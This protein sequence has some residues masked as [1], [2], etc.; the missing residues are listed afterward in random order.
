MKVLFFKAIQLLMLTGL[1]GILS[2]CTAFFF[3]PTKARRARL[4]E[5]TPVTADLHR[6]PVAKEK[7]ITAVYK[8]RDLT[9]QYK[10]IEA[11]STFST[12]VTQGTTNILLK[13]LEESGWF[14][15]IE[16]E[17]VSNLL[18]ERKI[19]RSS[20]A[21]YKEGENLPPLLFAGIILEGGVVSY[22]A[23]IITGGGGLQYFSAGG[24]TQYRQDRVTVYLRAV[25][26]KSGKILKTIYT[27]K[28]ILSQTV[29]ASLFRYVTFK[30]LLETETGL[31]TT[32]PGQLAVTEAIEKA[33][34]GLIIEG[35]RDGLWL[36]A[37]NQVAAMQAVV[38]DYE[39]EKTVMSET[40]VYG[41][42]PEVA[43]PF[44][45]VHT[46]AGA[47]RYYGDYA[48]RTIKGSY[49]ASVDF[50]IT[51][52]FGLQVNG[53]TGVLASEGAFSTNITSLE[54]NLILRLTPYQR[55]T[56]LLF[57]GAGA[58]SQSGSSPFQWRGASYLQA[59]GGV[60]V[61]FSP[62]KVIGFRST[63]SY[64]QPFTDALDSKVAG[65]RN[66]YYLRGTLGVVFHIG[67]FSPPKVK[68][69]TPQQP[70]MNK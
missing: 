9:G 41:I 25:S 7:I 64:N 34:Q 63:L 47:M 67:R 69:L 40:D 16:R 21:Q 60:G 20:V 54:G 46:Y 66:D 33:V 24:S 5:E 48:R 6:L 39:K 29:N 51:P 14:L 38:K 22:D 36:P 3:Q 18:N 61:Q 17:N 56:S 53:A 42:R 8:F 26:T 31:T 49:G 13:A 12:A 44:L 11:G 35:V 43:P 37:D 55:W 32:E 28:T 2:G 30:R 65:T 52:A 70:V 50:H 59:Q 62:S 10:Q 15:P 68:P 27:S 1:V 45:S 19:V 58:V 57:A 23:N 4:G